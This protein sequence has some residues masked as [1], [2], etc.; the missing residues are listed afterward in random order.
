MKISSR[1][2]V[3][4]HVLSLLALDQNEGMSSELLASSVNTN[5]VV[6]RRIIGQLKEAKLVTNHRG[7]K[8]A[9]LLHPFESISLLDVYHAV[10]SVPNTLFQIHENSN[11]D[12][13]V[14]SEIE[15]VLADVL[16][17]AQQKMEAYLATQT[18]DSIVKQIITLN[19]AKE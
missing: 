3:A 10:D 16:F 14:G 15:K 1:F 19:E 4:V 8:G 7:S 12:C 13:I 6:I 9:T 5:P 17:K 2:T 18:I 11:P